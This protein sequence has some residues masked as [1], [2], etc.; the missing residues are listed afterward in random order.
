MG[1]KKYRVGSDVYDIPDA[2]AQNFLKDFPDAVELE[3]FVV[4]KDTFDIP[5]NERDAFLADFPT[6]KPVKK[7]VSSEPPTTPSEVS[8]PEQPPLG[9]ETPDLTL[10]TPESKLPTSTPESMG[11]DYLQGKDIPRAKPPRVTTPLSDLFRTFKSSGLKNLGGIAATPML[12]NRTLANLTTKPILKLM[13][14]SDEE[15]SVLTEAIAHNNFGGRSVSAME[16]VQAPLRQ[17][18]IEIEKQM[19]QLDGD[20]WTNLNKGK[21]G[22]KDFGV[23]LE[24]F[25]RGIMGSIPF[26]IQLMATK[27]AGAATTFGVMASTSAAQQYAE[28]E[29]MATPKRLANGWLYGGFEALGEM[30]TYVLL[31]GIGKVFKQGVTGTLPPTTARGIAKGIASSIGLEGSSEMVT[32]IGQNFTAIVTGEDTERGL[33][34]HVWDAGIIGGGMG[35]GL[36][37]VNLSASAIGRTIASDKEVTE[38]QENFKQQEVL[39]NQLDQTDSDPVRN[40]LKKSLKD[41]RFQADEIIDK[42]YELAQ[43]LTPAEQ[44][45][46]AELYTVWNELQDRIDNGKLSDQ[47]IPALQK[48]IDGIKGQIQTVK[49]NLITRLEEQAKAEKEAKIEEIKDKQDT[50]L[51]KL[52]KQETKELDKVK[53]V[54]EGEKVNKRKL[55]EVKEKYDTK[56]EEV[57]TKTEEELTK[58]EEEAKD[59]E[60]TGRKVEEGGEQ[61]QGVVEGTEGGLRVR[62]VEE[63]GVEAVKGEEIKP[64]QETQTFTEREQNKYLN[65]TKTIFE[66]EPDL[67]ADLDVERSGIRERGF[68]G[69][70]VGKM[71]NEPVILYRGIKKPELDALLG[72]YNQ[73]KLGKEYQEPIARGVAYNKHITGGE[74]NSPVERKFGASYAGDKQNA[75]NAAQAIRRGYKPTGEEFVFGGENSDKYVLTVDAR[76]ATF[77]VLRKE[78]FKGENKIDISEFTVA[79]GIN[80]KLPI[81]RIVKIEKINPDGTLADMSNQYGRFISDN[82]KNLAPREP[83][84]PLKEPLSPESGEI[85]PPAPIVPPV[86][87]PVTGETKFRK[88]QINSLIQD[89]TRQQQEVAKIVDANKERYQVLHQADAVE[90]AKA[91]IDELG[92]GGATSELKELTKRTQEFPQRNVARMVLLN[93]YSKA[94]IDP[95]SSEGDKKVAFKAI[96]DLQQAMARD[97]TKAGQGIAMMRIWK[98]MQPAGV[99]EFIA[100]KIQQANTNTLNKK[101]GE[102]TLGEQLDELYGTLTEE[103]KNIIKDILA[104][105]KVTISD[106][107]KTKPPVPRK[108]VPKER[109]KI[110]QDYRKSLIEQY[111]KSQGGTLSASL[112]GLTSAQIELGGNLLASYIREGYYRVQDVVDKLKKDFKEAG[113]TLDDKQTEEIL[114]QDK[115]SKQTFGEYLDKKESKARMREGE[116]LISKK[117]SDVITEH[118]T[119]KDELK[120]TLAQKLMDEA[121][122]TEQEAQ[123]LEK[124]IL[125]KFDEEIINRSQKQLTKILGTEKIP[126]KKKTK[127]VRDKMIELI[128]MGALDEELYRNLFA[129]KFKLVELTDAH[130]EEILRLANNVQMLSGRGWLER[131][132]TI[133]L[134]K[135]IYELYPTSKAGE[136]METWMAMAYANML[137]GPSTSILN[138]A[139]AGSNML[140]KPIRE[141]TNLSKYLKLLKKGFKGDIDIYN[142]FGEMM[143]VPA[144]RGIEMGAKEMAEVYKN[145][146]LNNK[147]IEQIAKK[148]QFQ[149]TQ[150]ERNKYGTA[151]RFPTVN[152]K[153]G[154]KNI[155]LN[156]FNLY[157]YAGRN[158]AAQDKLMLTTSYEIELAHILRDKLRNKNLTGRAL[159]RE[160]MNIFKGEHIDMEKL[161]QKLQEDANLYVEM[162]GKDMTPLQFKIRKRELMLEELPITKEEK[163]EAERLARSNIFTDDRG[164]LFGTVAG[165]LGKLANSSPTAGLIVKP[166]VPFT[167][168]VGNVAE[169]MM[170]HV[171]YYGLLRANGMSVSTLAKKL[172]KIEEP[173]T[174][175]MGEKGSRAY[176]EQM[177]RAWLGTLTFSMAMMLLLGKDEEDFAEISGGYNEEGFKKKGRENVLPPYTLRIGNVKIPYKNI[178]SLAIPLSLIG[179]MNDGL[180]AGQDEGDLQDRLTASLL[181]DAISESVFMVKDM[182]FLDGVQRGTQII[183]DATSSDEKKW[184]QIGEGLLKSYLGF[185]T[186]PLPQNNNAIQQIWK[187]FDPVSY[188]QGDIKGMLGYA[189]GLQHFMGRP[190]LDQ[191]GDKVTSYPGET[192]M[193]YTHWLKIKG[194]DERWKFLAKYN[195]IPNKLYN[196]TMNIEGKDGLE[197]RQLEPEELYDYTSRTGQLFSESLKKY[198]SDKDKVTQRASDITERE[199]ANGELEKVNGIKEDVEKLWADAKDDA[200]MELFRWG[201]VKEDMPKTWD[202]IKQHQAYQMYQASKSINGQALD[203]SQLYEFNNLASMRYAEKVE[204]YLLSERAQVDKNRDTDKDGI[205]NFD[206]KIDEIWSDAKTFVSSRMEKQLKQ[207]K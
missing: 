41:L 66:T 19:Y 138:L 45:Q 141:V 105:K 101:L 92:V 179:N 30:A 114:G 22:E 11:L 203:K 123:R 73:E 130:K 21:D 108:T 12:Y 90:Q 157:K 193:P 200:E 120:R 7:K 20:I 62:D 82:L 168:V 202:L 52:K 206:E 8:S 26:M 121:G 192:L 99:L 59:A 204:K 198:M 9:L 160:V 201:S 176:Y 93:L 143:Y 144:L 64:V 107:L 197:K 172:A 207:Q 79:R 149:V 151:K 27:G 94:I 17:K 186:R 195:A 164:G 163:E 2:E 128:N 32:Q 69:F 106:E 3:S 49:D 180:K 10:K 191:F 68:S 67:D 71:P 4:D 148:N 60:S 54:A 119:E 85:V 84:A 155:D 39:I 18:A 77:G 111:K 183:A 110:E 166:F 187:I 196:R 122:L 38:V 158:L 161:Q 199:R 167:K 36:F 169:Y 182:S 72:G 142:P 63:N 125:E 102:T 83:T 15:A 126:T 58:V 61:P 175:Q 78:K 28:T 117:I 43:K 76:D 81:T 74:F 170:D 205:S 34:D 51:E 25:G 135:Y 88:T 98:E 31:G 112:T 139:S 35:L 159:T 42:N 37:G 184:G 137:S 48:T 16:D 80:T 118:W 140:L 132:A 96:D 29:G 173:L 5:I 91:M 40:A 178:P 56:V 53:D 13:G 87:T 181:L 177:G 174:A 33:F 1:E 24:Q 55:D 44:D 189:T 50:E 162:T 65:N 165:M 75:I 86:E 104:G 185:A 46:V 156:I 190:S 113:I 153:I 124:E 89:Q 70:E 129:E 116:K 6:A 97:N 152:V 145:G 150:L 23:A 154:G 14:K 115:T 47:E 103:S 171:P 100:R 194:T 188:S 57:K 147:Y 127:G 133:R 146:D 95:A 131:D 134:A 109:I 136:F